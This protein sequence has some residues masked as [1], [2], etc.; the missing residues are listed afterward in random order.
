MGR[1]KTMWYVVNGEVC[2]EGV[3]IEDEDMNVWEWK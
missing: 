2:I 3:R 1:V